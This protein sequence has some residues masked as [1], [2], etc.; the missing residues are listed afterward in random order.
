MELTQ[1][2]KNAIAQ[3]KEKHGTVKV[4]SPNGADVVIVRPATP[5]EASRFQTH[6]TKTDSSGRNTGMRPAQEALAKAV[7]VYP[8][9]LEAKIALLD[10]YPFLCVKVTDR[11]LAISGAEVEDLGND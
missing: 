2:Q 9:T 3:A 11:C 5:A 4:F 8:D 1:E 6:S 7:M 10:K